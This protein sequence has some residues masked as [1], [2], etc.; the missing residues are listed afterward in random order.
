MWSD[1]SVIGIHSYS[2]KV[3]KRHI[4]EAWQV[5]DAQAQHICAWIGARWI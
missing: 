4:V 1:I 2:K 3:S 5:F